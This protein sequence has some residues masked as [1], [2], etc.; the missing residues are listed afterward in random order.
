M[1]VQ[2]DYS[3]YIRGRGNRVGVLLIH[4]LA[5]TPAEMRYVANGVA[6]A[7]FTV[8]CPQLAGHGGTEADIKTTTWQDWYDSSEKALFELRKD[9][10]TVIVGGLSTG[11]VLALLLAARNPEHVHGTALM[12]PTFWLNGWQIPWYMNFFRLVPFKQVGNWFNFPD[13]E[14]HGIKDDRVREFVRAAMLGPGAN[15]TMATI[16]TPGGAVL[17]HRW[18]AKVT[19]DE[20]HKITQPTLI[21]HPREDDLADLSNA[22]HLERHLK[23]VVTTVVLED[24]YHIITIDRQRHVVV[25]RVTAFV[26]SVSKRGRDRPAAAK[27]AGMEEAPQTITVKPVAS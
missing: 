7:G 3:Y 21:L 9:C 13:H 26:E 27:P 15:S 12:A 23:G 20:L 4:G 1:A 25:E 6:R 22:W 24:C 14:P 16:T 5:G 19:R 18:L 11:A 17:E 2:K 10:E 8:F